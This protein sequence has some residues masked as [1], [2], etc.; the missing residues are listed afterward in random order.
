MLTRRVMA[1]ASDGSPGCVCARA[2][3]ASGSPWSSYVPWRSRH[4]SSGRPSSRWRAPPSKPHTPALATHTPPATLP[5]SSHATHLEPRYTHLH[6]GRP[7]PVRRSAVPVCSFLA[8]VRI[9]LPKVGPPRAH[10]DLPLQ[11]APRRW[12]SH[13]PPCA[14][15]RGLE[16]Q[17]RHGGVHTRPPLR[18]C[19]VRNPSILSVVTRRMPSSSSHPWCGTCQVPLGVMRA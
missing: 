15:A 18:L 13:L 10:T 14:P 8:A 1:S 17:Q 6:P 3:C 2:S 16:L 9:A 7:P 19:Q 11:A 12:P 4:T 5:T